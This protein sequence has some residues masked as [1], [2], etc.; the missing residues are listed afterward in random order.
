MP[1]HLLL[2]CLPP[3]RHPS[4]TRRLPT[5]SAPGPPA[6]LIPKPL[7]TIENDGRDAVVAA[8]A[9]YRTKLDLGF[10]V[11][12]FLSPQKDEQRRGI[13]ILSAPTYDQAALPALVAHL[14]AIPAGLPAELAAQPLFVK[15]GITADG[16]RLT[17]LPGLATTAAAGQL[18]AF[19][20][21]G[22][23]TRKT[24]APASCLPPV[25]PSAVV[26]YC[27]LLCVVRCCA[28]ALGLFGG[29]CVGGGG[30][31]GTDCYR[32]SRPFSRAV[33]ERPRGLAGVT[34]FRAA[35]GYAQHSAL[36]ALP[37][38]GAE[39]CE[40]AYCAAVCG[41]ATR[42]T[43]TQ[44][45]CVVSWREPGPMCDNR[46]NKDPKTVSGTKCL[47]NIYICSLAAGS[48]HDKRNLPENWKDCLANHTA[49]TTDGAMFCAFWRG[50]LRTSGAMGPE[51]SALWSMTMG[52]AAPR[53]DCGPQVGAKLPVRGL[54][55]ASTST[56][57]EAPRRRV[58]C[59]LEK[60][61]SSTLANR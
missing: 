8:M 1:A 6:V 14:G 51:A 30:G 27:R 5:C 55:I 39:W 35:N 34:D 31:G 53:S 15:Q 41:S 24:S 7:Q 61:P 48:E 22:D 20:V 10:L 40:W 25:S 46:R 2:P 56:T 26:R 43:Y 11:A 54:R 16:F 52:S 32:L 28:F 36:A 37:N 4:G 59:A 47:K 44:Q 42:S 58:R 13:A 23:I 9:A 45:K 21:S 12:F 18:V 57:E 3:P 38:G 49:F 29:A 50:D 19:E 60:A 33:Y 17:E